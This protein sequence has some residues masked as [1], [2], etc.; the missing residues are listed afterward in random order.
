MSDTATPTV[1]PRS[2]PGWLRWALIASLAVNLLFVGAAAA[3]WYVGQGPERYARLTQSQII[4]RNFFRDMGPA[5]RMEL[6]AILK[7]KDK[8]IRDG[9]RLVKAQVLALADALDAEPYDPA[10][11]K[12]AVQGFTARS[13]ALFNTGAD[14]AMAVID[15]LTPEERKLMARH[16]RPRDS[17]SRSS[18]GDAK[19]GDK[20]AGD[21]PDEP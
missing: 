5:R 21:A 2:G 10:R 1:P 14:A 20:P 6:M 7:S 17:R 4:P 12:A 18:S 3:R 15:T 19:V 16:L 9:R 11:V 13:E 8:E